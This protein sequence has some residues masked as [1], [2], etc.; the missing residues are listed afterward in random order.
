M[1]DYILKLMHCGY[2]P[3]EAYIIYHDFLKEYNLND[4]ISFIDSL[5]KDRCIKCG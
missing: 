3:H 5:R 2:S 4:L 1:N